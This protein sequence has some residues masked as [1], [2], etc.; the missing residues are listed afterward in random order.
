MKL[1]LKIFTY[2]VISLLIINLS[3]MTELQAQEKNMYFSLKDKIKVWLLHENQAKQFLNEGNV[4]MDIELDLTIDFAKVFILSNNDRLVVKNN[5]E[6]ILVRD[7]DFL[8]FYKNSFLNPKRPDMIIINLKHWFVD[9]DSTQ[10]AKENLSILLDL[11]LDKL[12]ESE[13]SLILIDKSLT[14]FFYSEWFVDHIGKLIFVYCQNLF[15]SKI[16]D[17]IYLNDLNINKDEMK[18]WKNSLAFIINY[19]LEGLRNHNTNLVDIFDELES[20]FLVEYKYSLPVEKSNIFQEL[21]KSTKMGHICF[22]PLKK[23]DK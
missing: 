10:L 4:K 23:E 20:K 7:E 1:L 2:K 16:T 12:D 3:I 21:N 9:S 5:N 14:N 15:D 13:P 6:Y 18:K 17:W 11:P 19:S 22:P 8:K